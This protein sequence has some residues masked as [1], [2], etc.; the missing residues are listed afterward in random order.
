M[1]EPALVVVTGHPASGKSS[2][3]RHLGAELG[4]VVLSKDAIKERLFDV[5]GTGDTDWSH[6]LGLA[7]IFVLQDQAEAV[8]A[9]GASVIVEAPFDPDLAS[10][11]LGELAERTG[12][13]CIRVVIQ[14]AADVLAER[15]RE[16]FGSGDR[17]P[18][19]DVH[20]LGV[21]DFGP[22]VAPDLS[23][24]LIEIDATE[25]LDLDQLTD[26]VRAAVDTEA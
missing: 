25:R 15:Y 2:A 8:L 23:G 14:A 12:A 9:G 19:H 10:K 20:L 4:I 21:E 1:G 7:S 13:R 3:A 16:R 5:L 11:E 26:E 17:H 18:G 6:K 22:Y 24:P